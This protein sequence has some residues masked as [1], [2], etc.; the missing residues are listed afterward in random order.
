MRDAAADAARQAGLSGA[1][2]NRDVREAVT[3]A[4]IGEAAR[5]ELERSGG[6]AAA[7]RASIDAAALRDV[8]GADGEHAANHA[9]ARGCF[10]QHVHVFCS[11]QFAT[12]MS[13]LF[14]CFHTFP[15]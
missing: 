2:A 4:L 12:R 7:W 13:H 11:A 8:E 15:F 3:D 10:R 9:V 6:K 14:T 5:K 1:E